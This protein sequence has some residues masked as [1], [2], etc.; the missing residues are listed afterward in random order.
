L[1]SLWTISGLVGCCFALVAELDGGHGVGSDSGSGPVACEAVGGRCVIGP[2]SNCDGTVLAAY[3]CNPPPRNAAGAICSLSTDAGVP[4][5][6]TI[7]GIHHTD[8]APDPTNPCQ[9]CQAF[10]SSSDWSNLPDGTPCASSG[11]CQGGVCQPSSPCTIGGTTYA[12]GATNPKDPSQCCSPAT[13]MSAWVPRLKDGGTYKSDSWLTGIA[14]ADFNQDRRVDLAILAEG[15]SFSVGIASVML[16]HADGTFGPRKT[17]PTCVGNWGISAGDLNGD[18]F[19]DLVT[20]GCNAPPGQGIAV[21]MNRGDKSGEFAPAAEQDFSVFAFSETLPLK[22]FDGDGILDLALAGTEGSFL[23]G[24]GDGGFAFPVAYPIPHAEWSNTI[25]AGPFGDAG[26]LDLVG[27]RPRW[28]L[29]L[30]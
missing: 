7:S 21:L 11:S 2:P 18:G 6:C 20:A 1:Q 5:S 17:Y 23:R 24:L 9:S 12:R 16:G 26:T 10:V 13:N 25:A 4:A 8:G 15:A 19:P 30:R 3:D 28:R 14:V 27:T 22:D 29:A